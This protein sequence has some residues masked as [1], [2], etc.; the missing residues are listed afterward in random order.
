MHSHSSKEL[1]LGGD[2]NSHHTQWGGT[3]TNEKSEL[4]YAYRLQSNLFIC[5]KGNDPTCITRSRREV[6]DFTLLS[7]HLTN[8]L[9]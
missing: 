3:N 9:V 4:L 2:A 8:Q 5:N 6:L 1:I 7:D